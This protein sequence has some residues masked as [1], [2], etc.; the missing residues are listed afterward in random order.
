MTDD[1]HELRTR[2][3]TQKHRGGGLSPEE[4]RTLEQL[5]AKS[6]AEISEMMKE[7]IARADAM[8]KRAREN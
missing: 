3:I 5:Q 8:L 7:S 2:L 1:E 4:S 6:S